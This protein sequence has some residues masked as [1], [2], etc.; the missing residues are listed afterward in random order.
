MSILRW[1][2]SVEDENAVQVKDDVMAEFEGIGETEEEIPQHVSSPPP[3]VK[4]EERKIKKKSKKKKKKKN[5]KKDEI[6][7]AEPIVEKL[8][9]VEK[10][11]MEM[12]I[13][14]RKIKGDDDD[15]FDAFEAFPDEEY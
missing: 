5:K 14:D 11:S 12:D 3:T 13:K 9:C 7:E 2:F 8:K 1:D 4:E 6:T 10:K 15:A